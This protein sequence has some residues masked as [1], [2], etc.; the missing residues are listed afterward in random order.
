MNQA[1][2]GAFS[3]RALD[4][5][6]DLRAFDCKRNEEMDTWLRKSA[7]RS[8][9]SD[10]TRVFVAADA[11][12]RA[13]GFFTLSGYCL[14][15]EVLPNG[16]SKKLLSRRDA[17]S[18]VPAHYIG[19]LAVDKNHQGGD[20]GKFLMDAA[21]LKYA[22]ILKLTTSSYLCLDAQNPGLVD[23]YKK[24]G[25]KPTPKEVSQGAPIPMYLKSSA[26]KTWV[27]ALNS[28]GSHL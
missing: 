28:E 14:E 5:A 12:N 3:L 8:H 23:Y 21:F 25:F 24:F 20:L 27:N 15:V 22:Q 11:N 17:K 19:R 13:L 16:D 2:D 10:V 4:A 9:E 1:I 6:H 7:L 18:T 26:I